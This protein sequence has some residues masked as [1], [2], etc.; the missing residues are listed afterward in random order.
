MFFF[1][2]LG[3]GGYN[4]LQFPFDKLWASDEVNRKG[5]IFTRPELN[6]GLRLVGLNGLCG[7]S[8]GLKSRSG[9]NLIE[10]GIREREREKGL[11][12][13]PGLDWGHGWEEGGGRGVWRGET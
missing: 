1:F 8:G 10:T 6:L 12:V 4:S 11:V 5:Q 9:P 7:V 2:Y 3:R 13:W